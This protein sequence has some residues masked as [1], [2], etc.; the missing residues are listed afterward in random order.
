[1]LNIENK[2]FIHQ[3]IPYSFNWNKGHHNEK[4]NQIVTN[5]EELRRLRKL[6]TRISQGLIPNN[7]FNSRIL[8]RV[9]QFKIKGLKS[10][11]VR[12]FSKI[13]IRSSKIQRYDS[14]SK[15]PT[16]VQNVY[17]NFKEINITGHP[18]HEPVLKSILIKDK[19]SLAIEIPIWYNND[20]NK[21]IT[22]HIDLIQI[23]DDVVKVIDYKP[24]GKFLI[25]LPQVAT[26]GILLKSKLKIKKLKCLTFN[27]NEA[28]EYDP[29]ILL[30]DI[31]K[32]LI[33]KSISERPWEAF[34]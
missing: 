20:N 12:S 34:L 7:L 26:Y 16:Y 2:L 23:N 6:F 10:A 17:E 32:Y 8:P 31:R 27:K 30:L 3:N 19:N 4:F 14:S 25:S 24:E 1:M 28:W 15:L 9:S 33:S 21:I 13:L 22:G 11:L 18:G 5:Q 29:N